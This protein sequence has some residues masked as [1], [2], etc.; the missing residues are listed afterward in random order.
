MNW[1][2]TRRNCWRSGLGGCRSDGK[3][4]RIAIRWNF[5]VALAMML[6]AA[7]GCASSNRSHFNI[8]D[9]GAHRDGTASSTDAIQS[10]IRA[11]G[12][13]GGGTVYI[14][15]GNYVSGPIQL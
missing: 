2:Q 5:L 14:P 10:A 7:S 12:R 13:S 8:L 11:A 4:V 9:F 6:L 15:P 1:I 3:I